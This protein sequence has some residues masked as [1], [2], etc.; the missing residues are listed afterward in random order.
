MDAGQIIGRAAAVSAVCGA[1]GGG[2]GFA[3]FGS[4]EAVFALSFLA[5]VAGSSA[6]WLVITR[7]V[8]RPLLS[9]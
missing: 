2:A 3:L 1:C 4:A 6:G 9:N 8:R 7:R 5:S